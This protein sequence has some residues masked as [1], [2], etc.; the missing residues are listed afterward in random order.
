MM[1]IPQFYFMFSDWMTHHGPM[2]LCWLLPPRPTCNGGAGPQEHL[3]V[4]Q[5]RGVLGGLKDMGG[6]LQHNHPGSAYINFDVCTPLE[7]TVT[8]LV[9][10]F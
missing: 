3:V 5:L 9:G 1:F 6:T 7:A 10:G 4:R 8:D 2:L